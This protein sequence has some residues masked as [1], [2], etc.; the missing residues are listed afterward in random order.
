MIART[1]S[2]NA[3]LYADDTDRKDGRESAELLCARGGYGCFQ[4]LLTK[5]PAGEIRWHMEGDIPEENVAVRRLVPVYVGKNTGVLGFTADENTVVDYVPRIAPFWVYDAMAEIRGEH[6]LVKA[7]DVNAALYV[8]VSIPHQWQA[9]AYE[10]VLVICVGDEQVRVPVRAEVSRA[11]I[12]EKE[13]LKIV[14]WCRYDC[15]AD[16][17][18]VKMWS[19]EHWEM[20]RRYGEMMRH[21]RQ[22]HFW[23]TK[24]LVDAHK[25]PDGSYQFDFS[26]ARRL[27]DLYGGMGFT[28][29]ESGMILEREGYDANIFVI[30]TAEGVLPALSMDGYR[31]MT[32]YFTQLRAVLQETGWLNRTEQ[33]VADEPHMGCYAEYRVLAGI[34][35]MLMPDVKLM[36]AIEVT[37]IYGALDIIIPKNFYY[38]ENRQIFDAYRNMGSELWHYTCCNPGGKR[39]NRTLDFPVLRTRFLHWGNYIYDLK[40]YLHWGLNWYCFTDHPFAGKA[41]QDRN[42]GDIE[43]PP[44]DTHILYPDTDRPMS[45]VRFEAMRAGI[46]DYELLCLAAKKDRAKADA[47]AAMCVR[48][49]E[50]FNEDEETFSRAYRMLLD[51]AAQ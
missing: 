31:Y 29:L 42:L 47:I 38:E 7:K 39:M 46:E 32:D 10:G 41:G 27:L 30:R 19:E 35:R 21:G 28:Y 12:P 13:T 50:D 43:L 44:G 22:T 20:I 45:S 15:M 9:K 11:V 48:S 36:D 24:D 25:Q 2:M 3:W 34:V 18:G 37:D 5:A 26:R 23:I 17:H 33:H 6:A 51:A 49:F 14:N 16:Y 40:G 1:V 8:F 4:V